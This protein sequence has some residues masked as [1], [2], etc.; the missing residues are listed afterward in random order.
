MQ[1]IFQHFIFHELQVLQR[2]YCYV[3]LLELRFLRYYHDNILKCPDFGKNFTFSIG[4]YNILQ[5]SI[6]HEIL[7]S[8]KFYYGN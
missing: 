6:F 8:Q 1:T 2:F 3:L 5:K 4:K 7:V